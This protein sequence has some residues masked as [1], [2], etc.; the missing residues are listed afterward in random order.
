MK[1]KDDELAEILRRHSGGGLPDVE[2]HHLLDPSED[3]FL[4]MMDSAP[5]EPALE[6][7][8]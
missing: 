4:H 6:E 2:L 7:S 3:S 8:A 1:I 5:V